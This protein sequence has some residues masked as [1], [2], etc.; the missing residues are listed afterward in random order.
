MPSKLKSEAVRLNG[1]RSRSPNT[2]EGLDTSSRNA[3]NHGFASGSAIVLACE[4]S[5]EFKPIL[6]DFIASYNPATP[7][8][9]SVEEM[10]ATHWRIRRLS[11]IE[12]SL[13]KV[14]MLSP[15][16]KID[17]LGPASHLARAFRELAAG[18]R[19]LALATRYESRLQRTHARAENFRTNPP[20][21]Q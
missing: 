12:T 4:D 15:R 20:A 5:A 2:P 14:E 3:L 1:F 21:L 9:D 6:N 19:S 18:S 16:T 7:A 10:V 17:S 13:I 8:E 11:T